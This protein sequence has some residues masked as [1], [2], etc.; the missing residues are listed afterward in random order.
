VVKGEK[1]KEIQF[2]SIGNRKFEIG[3]SLSI[4]PVNPVKK[5]VKICVNQCPKSPLPL[6]LSVASGG[7]QVAHEGAPVAQS[8]AP[9]AHSGSRRRAVVNENHQNSAPNPRFHSENEENT[10]SMAFLKR[11]NR[12]QSN[13]NQV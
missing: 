6:W 2:K 3:N 10:P 5:S 11:T 4:N 7:A 12:F 1:M 13:E 8:G 9:M